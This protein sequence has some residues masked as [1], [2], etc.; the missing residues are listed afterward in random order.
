MRL[1]SAWTERLAA[2]FIALVMSGVMSA[3]MIALNLG[4]SAAYPRAWLTSWGIGFLIS[5]PT[6]RLIVPPVIRWQRRQQ[7]TTQGEP[8]VMQTVIDDAAVV[9][10]LINT[11]A[12]TTVNQAKVTECLRR[13][14]EGYAALRP[15]FIAAS[16]HASLD[17]SRVVNYAQWESSSDLTTM[18]ASSEAKAHMA[19]LAALVEGI[20]PVFY[21]VTYV[22]SRAT[23]A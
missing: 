1:T 7:T 2:A 8:T 3:V 5:F 11:F 19:E 9:H 15:G 20:D 14:T 23:V 21:R 12:V 4:F 17:G 13:F 18:L 16:V 6:A 22:G 10:T